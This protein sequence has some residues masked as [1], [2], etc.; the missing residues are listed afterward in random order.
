MYEKASA[1]ISTFIRNSDSKV[2]EIFM[3]E[4]KK[5]ELGAFYKIL[6]ESREKES[7]KKLKEK[8]KGVETE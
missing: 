3:R 2:I 4:I 8:E 6:K 1:R 7:G 5:I